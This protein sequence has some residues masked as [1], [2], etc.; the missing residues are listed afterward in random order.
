MRET[1][2]QPQMIVTGPPFVKAIFKAGCA[3]TDHFIVCL[4][5]AK[6]VLRTGGESERYRHNREAQPEHGDHT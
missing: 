5:S 3:G 2:I 6:Q 1:K 4:S